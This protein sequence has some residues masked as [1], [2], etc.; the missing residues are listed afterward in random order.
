MASFL[1]MRLFFPL[2][3][4]FR[5]KLPKMACRCLFDILS[6]TLHF[7]LYLG[8][9][10]TLAFYQTIPLV[11]CYQTNVALYLYRFV[12]STATHCYLHLFAVSFGCLSH[13]N[14]SFVAIA[15]LPVCIT[16]MRGRKLGHWAKSEP[17]RRIA[18]ERIFSAHIKKGLSLASTSQTGKASPFPLAL[19]SFALLFVG[20]GC[21]TTLLLF[22]FLL[23]VNL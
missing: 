20:V 17:L 7:L 16:N 21:L 4:E 9:L 8:C 12:K 23:S 3:A 22:E 2:F 14:Q 5:S 15:F 6:Y 1:H 11:M 13:P 19:H 18:A 10:T